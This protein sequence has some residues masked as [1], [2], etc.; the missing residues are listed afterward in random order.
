MEPLTITICSLR[1]FLDLFY[2]ILH[3][4]LQFR[5]GF[6]APSSRILGS[7]VLVVDP[8]AV[9][10]RYLS[11]KFIID[12]LSIIP[13]PQLFALAIIPI[14][15]SA[16]PCIAKECLK[17]IVV[18]QYVPRI[19]RIYPLFSEVTRTSGILTKTAWAGA[20]YNLLLYM[21]ASHVVGAF[22]H[23][24]S[25]E[26]EI[27][28][29]SQELK[30][31]NL[32]AASY[33][34]CGHHNSTVISLLNNACPLIYPDDI[35]HLG[36]FNFGIFV[37][38]L[39]SRVVESTTNFPKKIFYC[40]WW[41]LRNLSSLGQ[42]LKTSTS[43]EEII[44]TIFI[45]I[46]GLVLFSF[47]IG[48]IQKYLQSMQS[49]AISAE[50]MRVKRQIMEK[51]M[52]NRK[53]PVSLR[54]RI[55]QYEHYKWQQHE[56]VDEETLINSL[57]KD[58]RRDIKR[59]L[60]FDLLK[61]VPM[62]EQME[63]QLLDALCD[64]LRSVLYTEKSY[65]FREGDQIDQMLFI[66]RGSLSTMTTNGRTTGFFNTFVMKAGDFCGEELFPWALDPNSS[67]LPISTRTVVSISKAEAFALTANDLKFV[68]SQFRQLHSKHVHHTFRYHSL[69]WR[70]WAA[71]FIQATW[72]RHLRVKI[73]KTLR[74]EEAALADE[75]GSSATS[76]SLG[77]AIYASVFVSNLT[78][79]SWRTRGEQNQSF[80]L[81]LPPKPDE[82]DF[83]TCN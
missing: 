20:A 54:E 82:P 41:G 1:T 49:T 51:W 79:R 57:P 73:A 27:Q 72:R 36:V 56:G 4:M 42:N 80:L 22:W 8:Q 21:L 67:I 39:R 15:N 47:L 50:E 40:F 58:L 3:A 63:E 78:L 62:F 65:I 77:A 12:I 76:L 18:V 74:E 28:C 29:W 83:S 7:D 70:T 35:D 59:H 19:V 81:R 25:V 75:Q 68:A 55:M 44:F 60:C 26:S 69:Q 52:S 24:F 16:I 14:T 64:R 32:S 38:A 61:Q 66:L 17:Y 37:D 31:A 23:L 5:A 11:S 48:N 10:K 2:I 6:I 43:I 53:L 9:A 71:C 45:A 46:F 30:N 33:M 34:S 13:L